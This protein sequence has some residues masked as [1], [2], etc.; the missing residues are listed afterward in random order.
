MKN[1]LK[2]GAV[3]LITILLILMVQMLHAQESINNGPFNKT[4]L[5][6]WKNSVTPEQKSA[7]NELFKTLAEE[8][9]GLMSV[10]VAELESDRFDVAFKLEFDSQDAEKIYM[11]HKQHLALDKMGPELIADFMEYKYQIKKVFKN[12]TPLKD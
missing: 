3:A 6:K 10:E 2:H 9:E 8:I 12:P 4:L 11:A 1:N 5:F 7:V